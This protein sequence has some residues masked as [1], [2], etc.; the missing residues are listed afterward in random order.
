MRQCLNLL[1]T[2]VCTFLLSWTGGSADDREWPFSTLPDVTPPIVRHEDWIRN[3]IDRF[4]LQRLEAA[5]LEPAA[6]ATPE[7][8]VRRLYLDLIGLPPHPQEV[9]AFLNDA[10][11]QAWE[12]LVDRL[13][14]DPRYGERW[15]RFWLDLARYADTAGYEGDPD[16]PHAWRYRDYVI[17]SFNR[18]KPYDLFIREQIA[19]DEFDEIMGAG[20]LPS[21]PAERVVA[22]TFLRLA[23]FTEPRGDES[24]HELL[25]EMTSTV[26]SVFLGLTVGC[27]KCHD[28]KYDN[29]PTKDFYR[30]KAF[31]STVSIPRPEPGDS[32]QIGGSIDAAFYREGEPEWAERRRAELQQSVNEAN[33]ELQAL[34]AGLS[35]R[36]GGTAGFGLQAMGG[37]LGNDYIFSRSKV[38]DGQLQLAIANCDGKQWT[39]FINESG[40]TKTGS[41]AGANQGQWFGDLRSPKHVALGA[42]SEGTGTIRSGGAYHVGEFS[43]ILIYDHPL[44]ASERS[45]LNDWMTSQATGTPPQ[46]GLLFWL[47]ASDLDADQTTPN[48]P[49]GSPVAH[50]KDRVA[51]IAISQSQVDQQPTLV[52][53]DGTPLAGVRF[54]N[55]FLVGPLSADA[56]FLSRQSGSL[57]TVF[58]ARHSHEGYGFEVG[59]DG[60]F[61]GTF[62]NPDAARRENIDQILA[63][64]SNE[65][66]SDEERRRYELLIAR[67]KF[68]S[69]HLRRLQP[70]AMSLRH[71][72][73][74]PYEPGVPVSR[75]MIR[76]EYD[77][78]GE[79][80]EAGFP[81][82]VT[83]HQDPAGIRL[84]PFKRWP[85]R[86]RRMALAEWIASPD[87]PL[88]ARV[89]VNR[90][91][92][93][94][95]GR[96]I[97]ATPSD[98]GTL[99]DGPS[100]PELLDWLAVEF[101]RNKWSLKAMHRLIVTSAT[102]RQT[103]VHLNERAREVDPDNSW[104]WRFR[105]RRLEAEAVRDSVL[106]VSGRLNA[107]HYGL[108]VFP[109][110]P[111]DIEERVKY[112]NSKWDTQ[113]GPEGRKR[114]IYIYQQRTLSMPFLQA[115]DAV[116]CDESRPQ[117]QHSV[118]PLQALA[119][120]N[121]DFVS[122]EAR[123]FAKRVREEAGSDPARQIVLAVRIAFARNPA[124]DEIERL[125]R[126]IGES[127]SPDAGLEGVCRV[128]LNSN[129]FVYVD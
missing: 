119:M 93:W 96:G 68:V 56:A 63:D 92:H 12:R 59:G 106:T 81:S 37:S 116:V 79:V 57:V 38:H 52:R 100:H 61:I 4:I 16:L 47:D 25:S 78:P 10:S 65:I 23:P 30:L 111:D 34:K 5:S 99:R 11:G 120:Y 112:S 41:N 49:A 31:F 73:G 67:E 27:A 7:Q 90:L 45:Q 87:N 117:R 110:L 114:S 3:D 82:V 43:Q 8:L 86:S 19:G 104:L 89:M 70:V 66:L 6:E 13:L 46:D 17:D 22:L 83:G 122:N 14:D 121:G 85:T 80:V 108:P 72:Y 84:D 115:F 113:H 9:D 74:P 124:D 39:F 88:T 35:G 51:G 98:F 40:P 129:E 26:S 44:N 102:Y 101:V 91:W 128:L 29:I 32:F 36:P 21:T 127:D 58:T 123:F 28:H 55:S 18:D 1:R 94:H 105:R 15:A 33:T 107:E 118:T 54:E 126:L 53:V 77:N 109:P 97:V 2:V 76:G 62:I 103:S 95:F 24:R 69:Q 50:W 60:S 125:T 75:V 48:P 64:A 71:S 20:E 42:Y